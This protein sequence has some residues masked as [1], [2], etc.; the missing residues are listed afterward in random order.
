MQL[1]YQHAPS[2]NQLGI[3]TANYRWTCI[4]YI[5]WMSLSNKTF[6]LEQHKVEWIEVIMGVA[7]CCQGQHPTDMLHSP[8]QVTHRAAFVLWAHMLLCLG[9]VIKLNLPKLLSGL[10]QPVLKFC[11]VKCCTCMYLLCEQKPCSPK[12]LIVYSY[13]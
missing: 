8:A 6:E 9:N 12:V 3:H 1:Q 13:V 7:A 2:Q 11:E 10:S 5:C 4:N